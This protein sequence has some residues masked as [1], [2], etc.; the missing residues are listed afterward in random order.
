MATSG[1]EASMMGLGASKVIVVVETPRLG[2][3]RAAEPVLK[4]KTRPSAVAAGFRFTVTVAVLFAPIATMPAEGVDWPP[5]ALVLV[6]H[7]SVPV[8]GVVPLG[9]V[10]SRVVTNVSEL[11][12]AGTIRPVVSCGV[13][14]RIVVPVVPSAEVALAT[15]RGNSAVVAVGMPVA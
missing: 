10:S 9:V 7:A 14:V 2:A 13:V 8:M 12:P 1:D 6:D 3:A 5:T 4:T 11:V 15:V